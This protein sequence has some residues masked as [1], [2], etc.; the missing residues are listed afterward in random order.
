[1]ADIRLSQAALK[2]L[3]F[4]MRAPLVAQSGAEIARATQVSSG[5][6]YPMLIRLE[7]A[8]WLRSEW[9]QIDPHE[10]GRPRKRFYNLTS[11]GQNSANCALTDLQMNPSVL[12]WTT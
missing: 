10:R 7:A 1:M 3:R 6:L 8:G 5:T 12:A 4:L 11:L 2:V 9:E